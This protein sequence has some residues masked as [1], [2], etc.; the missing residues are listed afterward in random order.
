[1]EVSGKISF[2]ER[3]CILNEFDVVIKE[4][5]TLFENAFKEIYHQAITTLPFESCNSVLLA[6]NENGRKGVADLIFGEL[7][8]LFRSSQLLNIWA[9]QNRKFYAL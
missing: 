9:K 8:G 7:V 6:E 4:C 3:A 5:G 1:M 2:T